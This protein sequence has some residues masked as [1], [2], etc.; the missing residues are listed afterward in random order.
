[1][2]N[3][4]LVEVYCKTEDKVVGTFRTTGALDARAMG[5]VVTRDPKRYPVRIQDAVQLLCLECKSPLYFRDGSG[6]EI[7]ALPGG[8][9]VCE[10]EDKAAARERRLNEKLIEEG[11]HRGT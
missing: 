2:S 5:D 8:S 1:M 7:A 3:E 6:T 9:E 11:Q 4:Y 10:D